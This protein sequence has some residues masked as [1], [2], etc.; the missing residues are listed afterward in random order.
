MACG[1]RTRR[2][3]LDHVKPLYHGGRHDPDNLQVLCW[4]C[5]REKGLKVVDY[6]TKRYPH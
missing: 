3:V 1:S 6:R 5:N 2:L 4:T